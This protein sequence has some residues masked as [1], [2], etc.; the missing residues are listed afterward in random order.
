VLTGVALQNIT[1]DGSGTVAT[2]LEMDSVVNSTISGVTIK[3]P[4]SPVF[5]SMYGYNLSW[6]NVTLIGGSIYDGTAFALYFQGNPSVN[7]LSISGMSNGLFGFWTS[8]VAN[9]T[10]SNVTVDA[11]GTV[12]RP[13]KMTGSAY[14]TFNSLTVKNGSNSSNG[15]SLEYYSSH[16][17]FSNCIVTNNSPSAGAGSGNAGINLFGNFVN[18]NSFNNCT[19]T[20]NGNLQ[21]YDSGWWGTNPPT[22]TDT[23][24]TISGGTYTG[25]PGGSNI[26]IQG[27]NDYIHNVT[28]NGSGVYGLA[29]ATTGACVNNNTVSGT[30]TTAA[31]SSSNSTNIGSGNVIGGGSSDLTAGTCGSSGGPAP[32]TGL[33]AS[34]Q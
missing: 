15:I 28:S 31:I 1:L 14:N 32:P 30:W 34:V 20:G 3:N 25:V 29:L 5:V 26:Y 27:T 2:G 10:F 23:G 9:G 6:I 8:G 17:A 12:G 4:T 33:V 21:Y 18:F 16:N 11:T 19:V 24:N 22:I 7:G 13:F